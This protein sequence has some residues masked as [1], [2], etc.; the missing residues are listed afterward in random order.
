MALL[1][2]ENLARVRSEFLANMSHEI[3]TPLN[4]VLGFAQI[5]YRNSEDSDKARNAFEKILTSGKLLLGIIDEILDF[6]KIEAGKLG[7]EQMEVSLA[8]V[9]GHAVELIG[10]RARAK[11]LEV[12]VQLESDLPASCIS[13]PLRL[14]Q[15]LINL[16]SNAV[17]FTEVGSVE[18]SVSRQRDNLLFRVSDTGIGIGTDQLAQLFNPFQQADGSTSRRFGGTGLGLAIS[19]RILELMGGQI[20]VESRL[21]VG[22]T[23]EFQFPYVPAVGGITIPIAAP[24]ANAPRIDK[25]LTGVTILVAEDN[26]IN[27]MVLE[28][29]LGD[30]GA[31]VVLV[32]NG[33][34]AVQRV[35]RDG[36]A[37]YDLVLMDMQMPEMDGLEATR[38]ILAFA[39][40]LPI[41]G[42]T[43]HAFSEEREKC[44]AAGM[45]AHIAKPID[46]DE[47][48]QLVQTYVAARRGNQALPVP[49]IPRTG[50]P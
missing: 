39:P 24:L 20:R 48:V 23:F 3:R 41:I 42:Q 25:P 26:L 18:L 14:G 2:A 21:G 46:P 6:S 40:D 17:K 49:P 34:E 4:G 45:V 29:T 50:N 35:I 27:Q 28:E 13:D 31:R 36:R 33:Q 10:D 32:S 1:A 38:R 43:A 8:E 37:A 9:V 22:S 16:L 47:L 11:R 5:G 44:F 12:R 7:I 30:D 19:K 15:V